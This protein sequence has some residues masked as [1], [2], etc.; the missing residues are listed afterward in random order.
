MRRL[1]AIVPLLM[2]ACV[3]QAPVGPAV[4][5]ATCSSPAECDLKWAAARTFVLNHAGYKFQ[6][7]TNDFM[8]TFNPTGAS[9]DLGA[10]V[11]REPQPNGVTLIAAKFW[12]DNIFGCSP[13]AHKTLNDFNETLNA[14]RSPD[15]PRKA[16]DLGIGLRQ[17]PPEQ[18]DPERPGLL[19]F[20]V[21]EG[22]VA[23]KAGL[24]VGDI[25]TEVRG[26]A[27]RQLSEMRVELDNATPGQNVP[28]KVIRG[29]AKLTIYV[30]P[31]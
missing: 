19:V 8:E 20:Q 30:M 26:H 5:T 31:P 9:V 7:Y 21:N 13:D 27:V 22:S 28:L 10:Q 6:T 23:Q 17:F 12:C 29:F 4:P 18:Q 14:I 25:I 3:T 16:P 24:L 15:R 11:N 2:T 1:I